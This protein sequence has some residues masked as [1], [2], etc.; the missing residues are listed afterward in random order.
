[1][2]DCAH[3]RIRGRCLIY[4]NYGMQCVR[5]AWAACSQPHGQAH[6]CMEDAACL[7]GAD[8]R[9]SGQNGESPTLNA[10]QLVLLDL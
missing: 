3:V 4:I 5:T 2:L 9:A 6:P 10:V 7:Y 1:M 8:A